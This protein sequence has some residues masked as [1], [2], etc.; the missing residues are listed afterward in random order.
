[1]APW[2]YIVAVRPVCVLMDGFMAVAAQ[3]Y[4]I[5]RLVVAAIPIDMMDVHLR[6]TRI[7]PANT[8]DVVIA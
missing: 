7:S 5:A 1:M 6:L 2:L 4:K 3:G 8:T